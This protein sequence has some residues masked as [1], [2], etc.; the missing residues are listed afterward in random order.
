MPTNTYLY[1][2]CPQDLATKEKERMLKIHVIILSFFQQLLHCLNFCLHKS[3]T[4]YVF[5]FALSKE[6]SEVWISY[7]KSFNHECT[8]VS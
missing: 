1:I 4:Y 8:F 6:G 3:R 7:N 5:T 2:S